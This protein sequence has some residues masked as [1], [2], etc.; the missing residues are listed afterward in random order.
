MHSLPAIET[1]LDDVVKDIPDIKVVEIDVEEHPDIASNYKVMGVLVLLLQMK[2][3]ISCNEIRNDDKRAAKGFDLT[4]LNIVKFILFI[5]LLWPLQAVSN[6]AAC[7][8]V[9]LSKE[10]A[11]EGLLGKRAVFDTIKQE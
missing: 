2:M 4:M 11:T 6:D 10:A 8:V 5:C 1:N 3:I 9:T 7:I